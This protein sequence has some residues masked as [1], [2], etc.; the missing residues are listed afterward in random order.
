MWRELMEMAEENRFV[1]FGGPPMSSVCK[2]Q[3]V[4]QEN[5]KLYSFTV[6]SIVSKV[7]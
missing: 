3:A 2:D 4:E 7:D 6:D 5:L 1:F